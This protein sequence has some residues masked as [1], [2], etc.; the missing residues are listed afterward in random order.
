M[1]A[2]VTPKLIRIIHL[3]SAIGCTLYSQQ[4]KTYVVVR[5]AYVPRA[6]PQVIRLARERVVVMT[7]DE[8][9]EYE[10][11][12]KKYQRLLASQPGDA[13]LAGDGSSA[14]VAVALPGTQGSDIEEAVVPAVVS[15]GAVAPG[16][17]IFLVALVICFGW[18][19]SSALFCAEDAEAFTLCMGV[20]IA[21]Q[22]V[23]ALA[24]APA[25]LVLA[26]LGVELGMAVATICH[27]RG[28]CA[29]P[30]RPMIESVLFVLAVF[31][32]GCS[33]MAHEAVRLAA[34][35]E[36]NDA[37][38]AITS[39]MPLK[40]MLV[41]S[42]IAYVA[43]AYLLTSTVLKLRT[44]IGRLLGYIA[45]FV[46]AS[47]VAMVL[48]AVV[49]IVAVAAIVVI[50]LIFAFALLRTMFWVSLCYW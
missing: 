49:L 31:C 11:L 36:S 42:A 7:E 4:R 44:Y 3:M 2:A 1:L 40:Q 45:A 14:S 6:L 27:E 50:G 35:F 19:F 13:A 12:Q 37:T 10:A 41:L 29:A 38:A 16:L 25:V 22:I 9:R 24:Y 43:V 48:Y 15:A 20:N 26:L 17:T 34:H 18:W 21:P 47:F 39:D 30:V 33:L 23:Q 46:V 8:Y 32:L 28:I 5:A